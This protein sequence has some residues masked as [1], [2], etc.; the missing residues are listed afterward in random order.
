MAT[1]APPT[2]ARLSISLPAELFEQLDTMVSERD[3][4]NRSQMIAELIRGELA[5]HSARESPETVL[6]GTITLIYRAESGRVRQALAQVQLGF[7]AEIISSQHV[8]LEDDQS[9]EVLLVQGSAQRLHSLCDALRKVRGTQQCRLIT[10]TALL[11]PL[12]SK[13]PR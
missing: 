7:I 5:E 8:F 9:L 10:T 2:L 11:P 4:A 3:V 12:S 1:T 6:A 13:E